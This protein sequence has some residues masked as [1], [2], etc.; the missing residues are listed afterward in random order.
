MTLVG[1]FCGHSVLTATEKSGA[2]AAEV[3]EYIQGFVTTAYDMASALVDA[4]T[5]NSIDFDRCM[6]DGTEDVCRLTYWRLPKY[7]KVSGS[8]HQPDENPSDHSVK[9]IIS[10]VALFRIHKFST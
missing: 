6:D 2:P 7:N 8:L 1:A 3:L 5:M 9:F 10:S 4:N